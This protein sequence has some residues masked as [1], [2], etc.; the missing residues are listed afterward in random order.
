MYATLSGEKCMRMGGD[1]RQSGEKV[2]GKAASRG[3]RKSR[4]RSPTSVL[5]QYPSV[6]AH[7]IVDLRSATTPDESHLKIDSTLR[8][9]YHI[10]SYCCS[11]ISTKVPHN[12]QNG[13]GTQWSA[14]LQLKVISLSASLQTASS[15]D[16]GL[17]AYAVFTKW[18]KTIRS[19]NCFI[20]Q[21]T[22]TV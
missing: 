21:L 22:I 14:N 4:S 5:P 8:S 19:I 12:A 2:G 10:N 13:K 9:T 18:R 15:P 20:P 17:A 7:S 1:G 16:V 3:G 6:R 11:T